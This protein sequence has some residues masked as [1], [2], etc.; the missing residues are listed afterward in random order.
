MCFIS[1]QTALSTSHHHTQPQE[2]I[3]K[4]CVVTVRADARIREVRAPGGWQ[5]PRARCVHSECW[6]IRSGGC[7]VLLEDSAEEKHQ[8]DN[9]LTWEPWSRAAHD[10]GDKM[11][12]CMPVT[13]LYYKT[14]GKQLLPWGR[15]KTC[16]LYD[17]M[18]CGT[19]RPRTW[20]GQEAPTDL[21]RRLE[22][23]SSNLGAMALA[24]IYN[25][26]GALCRRIK[27]LRSAW[28]R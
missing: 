25:Y 3:R 8:Q 16:P 12:A 5:C 19:E 23:P 17:S 6:D 4:L 26:M 10:H 15:Q 24:C 28:A 1:A 14:L 13:T 9:P 11:E 22:N 18:L 21:S 7:F 20:I 27:S 2:I